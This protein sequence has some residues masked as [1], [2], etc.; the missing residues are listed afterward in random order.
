MWRP[1]SASLNLIAKY[2]VKVTGD[3]QR[4]SCTSSV[5]IHSILT[6]FMGGTVTTSFT[7]N[8]SVSETSLRYPPFKSK[9]ISCSVPMST[10][11]QKPALASVEP[12]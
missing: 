5:M 11:F 1:L 12:E 4:T 3:V 7:E 2:L 6:D 8:V 10:I 9:L